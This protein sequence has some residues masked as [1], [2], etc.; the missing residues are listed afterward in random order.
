VSWNEAFLGVIALATLIMA[1]IQV[2]AVIAAARIAKQAQQTLTTV[3]QDIRPL[4]AKVHAVAD[5][6]SRTASLATAQA[7]KFDRLVTDLSERVEETTAIVQQAIIMPA[8]EG[9]A[10]MAA[11]KAGLAALRGFR[12]AHPRHGRTADEE[13]PLFIG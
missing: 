5:E 6:A 3:Q 1:L 9:M 12:D 13:D 4:I 7:Q 2:G 11:L 8:R 10:V